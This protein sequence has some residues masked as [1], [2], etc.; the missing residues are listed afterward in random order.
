MRK[1]HTPTLQSRLVRFIRASRARSI[2]F[3]TLC[4]VAAFSAGLQTA[5]EVHPFGTS[6]AAVVSD[7]MR[8]SLKGDITGDGRL[9][10]NDAA[11][12]LECAEGLEVPTSEQIRSGDTDGD[13]QLTYKDTLR[14][15]HTLS[16]R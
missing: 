9:D 5:G 14:V 15:L 3:A 10:V 7:A 13:F 8:V 11:L 4:A 12:I 2:G 6:Q 1:T 16:S